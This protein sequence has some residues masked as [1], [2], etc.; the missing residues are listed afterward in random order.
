MLAAFRGR[1]R[2]CECERGFTYSGSADEQCVG[3][4]LEPASEQLVQLGIAAGRELAGKRFVMLG[5]H[6]ARE[7]PQATLCNRKV[8]EAAAESNAAHLDYADPSSLCPVIDRELFEHDDAVRNRMQLQIILGG[9]EIVEEHDGAIAVGEEMLQG[10]HLAPVTKRVLGKQT[11]LGKAVEHDARRVDPLDLLEDQT[12]RFAQLHLGGMED[13]ELPV[14]IERGL[15]GDQLKDVHALQGPA[16][17]LC[18]D[19]QLPLGLG[20]GDIEHAFTI[21]HAA[22]KELQRNRGFARARP[23]LVQ[24]H[25]IGVEAAAQNVIQAVAASRNSR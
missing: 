4:A 5:R 9:R 11:Q 16:V 23:P 7:D 8:V 12:G 1:Y 22:E 17:P 6:E 18:D 14:R 15:G 24:I 13:R 20:Q 10:Q 25:P 3:A 19:R 2:I 21:T